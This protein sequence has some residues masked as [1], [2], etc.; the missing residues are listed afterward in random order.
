VALP[1]AANVK[2]FGSQVT[3][4]GDR[5]SVTVPVR[6]ADIGDDVIWLPANSTGHGLLADLASPGSRVEVTNAH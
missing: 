6:V 2:R 5:G 3:V 4:T 1:S